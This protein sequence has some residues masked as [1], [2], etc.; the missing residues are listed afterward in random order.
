VIGLVM[1]GSSSG[2]AE[3]LSQPDYAGGK[4]EIFTDKILDD[5][6]KEPTELP[7]R[8]NCICEKGLMYASPQSKRLI[9][10]DEFGFLLI[11]QYN[12]TYMEI[13]VIGEQ[14]YNACSAFR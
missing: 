6:Y 2:R 4:K 3:T 5:V 11:S 13:K 12:K 1:T 9:D 8:I 10:H 14:T 7:R